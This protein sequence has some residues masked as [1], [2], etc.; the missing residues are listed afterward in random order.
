MFTILIAALTAVAGFGCGCAWK[1]AEQYVE[2][3]E[4]QFDELDEM[5]EAIR[6]VRRLPEYEEVRNAG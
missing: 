1:D 4:R 3:L 5:V 6:Q 2:S